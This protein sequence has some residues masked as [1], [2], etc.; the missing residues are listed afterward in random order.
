M[1]VNGQIFPVFAGC[2][3]LLFVGRGLESEYA[4]YVRSREIFRILGVFDLEG[5]V[6][7]EEEVIAVLLVAEDAV[8]ILK[9]AFRL[10]HYMLLL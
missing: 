1:I 10:L 3:G 5:I 7:H 9:L 6:H 8:V 4:V 2:I